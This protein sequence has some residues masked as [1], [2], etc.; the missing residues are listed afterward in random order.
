MKQNN[1]V[2]CICVGNWRDKEGEIVTL[3]KYEE[4]VTVK[5]IHKSGEIK[6]AIM[7]EF[8]EYPYKH[9]Y[10]KYFVPLQDWEE[11]TEFMEKQKEE[12]LTVNAH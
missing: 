10:S 2:V 8:Y 5:R 7:F 11:A 9:Y 4:V 6:N 3:P 1:K 12:I